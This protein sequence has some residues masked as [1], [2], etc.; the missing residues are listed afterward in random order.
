[1]IKFKSSKAISMVSLVI[2][3]ILL[4]ILSSITILSINGNDGIL[5]HAK[6]A[7]V[8]SDIADTK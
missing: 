1:M 5:F 6:R 7:K 2:T 4:V 3:I 8:E